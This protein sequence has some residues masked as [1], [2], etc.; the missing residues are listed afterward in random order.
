[1]VPK[2]RVTQNPFPPRP[3]KTPKRDTFRGV[4]PVYVFSSAISG[5]ALPFLTRKDLGMVLE[6][7]GFWRGEK[8]KPRNRRAGTAEG[9]TRPAEAPLDM[10][11]CN[12]GS[13]RRQAVCIYID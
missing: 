12:T 6:R 11:A 2:L 3:K 4:L 10:V 1:M 8:A 5:L 7:P 9:R 13:C